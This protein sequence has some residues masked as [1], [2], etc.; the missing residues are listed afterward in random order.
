MSEIREEKLNIINGGVAAKGLIG[1]A[2]F[3]IGDKVIVKSAPEGGIGT[4]IKSQ[5]DKGWQYTVRLQGGVLSTYEN[6]LQYPL[7]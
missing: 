3:N 7:K 2:K 6:G 4:V 5:Y 1:G